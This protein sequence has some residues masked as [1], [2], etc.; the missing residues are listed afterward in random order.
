MATA[1][2]YVMRD[3][4]GLVKLGISVDPERRRS[5]LGASL[6]LVHETD[7]VDRAEHIEALAHRLLALHGRHVKGE[8]FEATIDDALDAINLAI[9]QFQGEQLPLGGV[10]KNK[11]RPPGQEFPHLLHLRI[12]DEMREALEEIRNSRLE[13]PNMTSLAREALAELIRRERG[14]LKKA[15]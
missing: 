14:A 10:F 15:S 4:A 8:W 6:E 11:G 3:G 5:Q 12:T 7:L 1:K 13:R 2:L 9:K